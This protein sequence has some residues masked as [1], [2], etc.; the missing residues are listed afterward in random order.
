M[1]LLLREAVKEVF[2]TAKIDSYKYFN[3]PT[4]WTK[5]CK[6]IVK[7]CPYVFRQIDTQH[8]T[9]AERKSEMDIAEKMSEINVTPKLYY[10]NPETGI[11]I[12]DYINCHPPNKLN[13]TEQHLNLIA[14]KLKKLH[15]IEYE[16]CSKSENRKLI[17][18]FIKIL[19]I[20]STNPNF[21]LYLKVIEQYHSLK[22]LVYN[23]KLLTLTHQDLNRN[24]ILI[25]DD[26]VMFI[27]WD[28]TM[29]GDPYFDLA[30]IINTFGMDDSQEAH[31]VNCYFNGSV[32]TE[33]KARLYLNRILC[34]LRYAAVTFS[35]CSSYD[36]LPEPSAFLCEPLPDFI[37]SSIKTVND[38]VLYKL[39][40]AFCQKAEYYMN[41][42]RYHEAMAFFKEPEY[43]SITPA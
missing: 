12:M 39:S 43:R 38:T 22:G 2:G 35:F 31:L 6:A 28:H 23:K 32:N 3:T 19:Q 29:I 7:G 15:S 13:L 8:T 40:L 24:N 20:S 11:M 5:V 1:D 14:E 41:S 21:S 33:H 30:K 42:D 9:H 10:N 17:E 36:N 37:P 34:H 4:Y 25:T 27:D 26:D 16:E 18:G